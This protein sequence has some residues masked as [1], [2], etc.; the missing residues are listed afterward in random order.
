[1]PIEITWLVPDKIVLERW[2]GTIDDNHTRIMIEEMSLILD[3]A[4]APVHTLLDLSEV[5]HIS[6]SLIYLYLQSSIPRHPNRGRICGFSPTVES[7]I[8]A[9]LLNR[10]TQR[11][12]LRLFSNREEARAYLLSHDSPPPPL[13]HGPDYNPRQDGPSASRA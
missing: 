5:G 3:T 1:M 4:Q 13:P 2:F 10:I 9:D 6:P 8:L 12:L 11:E 7:E